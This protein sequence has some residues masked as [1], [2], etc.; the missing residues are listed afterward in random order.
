MQVVVNLIK[1]SYEAMDGLQ[2]DA[3]FLAVRTFTTAGHV[4]LEVRDSGIGVEPERIGRIFEFGESGKGSSGFGLYYCSMFV[5]ANMGKLDFISD[6]PGKGAT[7][8]LTFET[9]LPQHR[10]GNE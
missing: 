1:N 4:G 7:V 2:G 8:R 10:D 3:P 5:E 9:R 6:G